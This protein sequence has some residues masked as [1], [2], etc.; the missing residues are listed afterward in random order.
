MSKGAWSCIFQVELGAQ[1]HLGESRAGTHGAVKEKW[2]ALVCTSAEGPPLSEESPP[3]STSEEEL[4]FPPVFA[5]D[6]RKSLRSLWPWGSRTKDGMG[7]AFVTEGVRPSS[8]SVAP[9]LTCNPGCAHLQRCS[10]QGPP[11][12]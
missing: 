3:A 10:P 11:E 4:G 1:A 2:L 6:A 8:V 7:D 12:V 5:T 9:G